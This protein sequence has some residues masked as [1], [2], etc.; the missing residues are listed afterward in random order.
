VLRGQRNKFLRSLISVFYTGAAIFLF[1]YLLN[2]PHEA[3]WTAFQTPYSSENLVGPGIEPWSSGYVAR[4]SDHHS[5][6][7]VR[8]TLRSSKSYSW[9]SAF[10]QHNNVST[11]CCC[12]CQI[13]GMCLKLCSSSVFLW[14]EGTVSKLRR[15]FA[16]FSLRRPGF[17]PRSSHVGFVVD[18]VEMEQVS[19]EYFGL[20]RQFSPHQIFH[21]HLTS[22]ADTGGQLLADV[23]SSV[24]PHPTKLKENLT[25]YSTPLLLPGPVLQFLLLDLR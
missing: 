4:N 11:F 14:L 18:K 25:L 15:L 1:K 10:K 6:E 13:Q 5:T 8:L 7:A 22:G 21:I 12:P 16:G 20:S 2:C 19:F 23:P 17:D 24:S 3:E 9:D